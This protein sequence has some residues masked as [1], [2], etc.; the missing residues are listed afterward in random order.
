M[1]SGGGRCRPAGPLGMQIVVLGIGWARRTAQCALV[2]A[3]SGTRPAF[4]QHLAPCRPPARP[5]RCPWLGRRDTEDP[6]GPGPVL[7]L[8]PPLPLSRRCPTRRFQEPHCSVC[9]PLPFHPPVAQSRRLDSA[10]RPNFHPVQAP[11]VGGQAPDFTAT[12]VFDQEFVETQL[13]QYRVSG[14][15]VRRKGTAA[16]GAAC[17]VCRQKR[18]R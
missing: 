15:A 9:L 2:A 17:A 5:R 1:L 11:L 14:L 13:S 4:L 16:D 8:P 6:P 7:P 18:A 3:P 12:A 10:A